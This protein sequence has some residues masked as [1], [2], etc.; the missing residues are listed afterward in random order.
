MENSPGHGTKVHVRPECLSQSP[1][2]LALRHHDL[3][4]STL[5]PGVLSFSQKPFFFPGPHLGH[6]MTLAV[7]PPDSPFDP[8]SLADWP[9]F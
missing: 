4:R 6:H 3:L 1:N 9:C 2:Q 7:M 8:N 5:H